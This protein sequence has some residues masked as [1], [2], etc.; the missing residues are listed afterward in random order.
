MKLV[1]KGIQFTLTGTLNDAGD[2]AYRKLQKLGIEV[3]FSKSKTQVL[4]HEKSPSR[5]PEKAASW[6][7]PV[8]D[9][10]QLITLVS[11]GELS[12]ETALDAP[13]GESSI[14]ELLGE[15]RALIYATRR[16]RVTR[17]RPSYSQAGSQRYRPRPCAGRVLLPQPVEHVHSHMDMGLGH[18]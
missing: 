8:I 2:K 12:L 7:I 3:A 11:A 5:K 9:E 14:D 10:K 15:V 6:G 1:A 4:I 13:G 17:R 16:V 18:E